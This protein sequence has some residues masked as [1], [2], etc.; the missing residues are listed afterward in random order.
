MKKQS[1]RISVALGSHNGEQFIGEQIASILVQTRP[2]DEIVLS[3]DASSDRTIEIVEEAVSAHRDA[4]GTAPELVVLRNDPPLRVTKNF[5]QALL[6]TTGDLVALCDQDD[7]W[8]PRRI[9][10]LSAPFEDD[11]VL[12]VFSNARQVDA[13]GEPLGHNLFEAAAISKSERALVHEGFA[14]KQFLRRNLATGAT[15]LLRRVLVDVAAPFPAAWLHDEWLA[16]I[17]AAFDG[18]CVVDEP[19]TDYRQH[20]ANQIGM[21]KLDL[22]RMLSMFAQPRTERDRRLHRRAQALAERI[23]SIDGPGGRGAVPGE[24]QA[25]AQEKYLFEQ[26]RQ[27]YPEARVLR[28]APVLRQLRLGRYARYG[29]GLKDAVR[30][31]IQPV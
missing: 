12:L 23:G 28:L 22:P 29:T 11:A 17:A 27:A 1:P 20:G 14:F 6:A 10:R 18:V 7:V 8:H 25:M 30:N 24:F 31:L 3:D 26:A 4:H 5:E 15:V 9:E 21:R 13:A 16:V 19:L 2:V